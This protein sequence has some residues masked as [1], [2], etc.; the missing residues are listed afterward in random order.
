MSKKSLSR[1]ALGLGVF[2]IAAASQASYTFSNL[3]GNHGVVGVS[4]GQSL[5]QGGPAVNSSNGVIDFTGDWIAGDGSGHAYETLSFDYDVNSTGRSTKDVGLVLQGTLKGQAYITF[6][7]SIFD[8]SAGS[9]RLVTST[10]FSA[11]SADGLTSGTGTFI[12]S[13]DGFAYQSTIPVV[14]GLTDYRVK[15]TAT[16]WVPSDYTATDV[17][18]L[19]LVEQTHSGDPA[20]VPEP[21]SLAALGIGCVGVLRRRRKK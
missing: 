6:T 17:A 5:T 1:V 16:L 21:A 10:S 19:E 12:R 8:L 18:S 13:G 3:N 7:E 11:D 4:D 9:E 14:A 15:K 20:P 2:A